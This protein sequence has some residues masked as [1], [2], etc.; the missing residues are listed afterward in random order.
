M[1]YVE[2]DCLKLDKFDK[3]TPAPLWKQAFDWF[4]VNYELTI[5][6]HIYKDGCYN[7]SL[8]D[9]NE[10]FLGK[11]CR[12]Y[13]SSTKFNTYEEARE[14]SLRKLIELIEHN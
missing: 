11:P 10:V 1:S 14:S 7:Y 2:G 6:L 4:R 8:I 12:G 3:N 13:Y 9:K 5:C